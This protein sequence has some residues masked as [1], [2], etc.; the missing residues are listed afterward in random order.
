MKR[1]HAIPPLNDGIVHLS[2][3]ERG[4]GKRDCAKQRTARAALFRCIL[5]PSD[6]EGEDEEEE[7]EGITAG[8]SLTI[9]G[10]RIVEDEGSSWNMESIVVVVVGVGSVGSVVF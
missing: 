3:R 10:M 4:G 2:K 5:S 6:D 9:P 7:E 8:W 1:E